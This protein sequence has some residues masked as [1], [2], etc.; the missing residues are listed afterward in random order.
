MKSASSRPKG[1]HYVKYRL[2]NSDV[3]KVA[4]ILSSRSQPRRNGKYGNYINLKNE[5]EPDSVNWDNVSEWKEV[6]YPANVLLLTNE[7]EYAQEVV[8]ARNRELEK[9]TEN[10]VYTTVPYTGQ[11]LISSKWVM[12][13]KYKDGKKVKSGC[14]PICEIGFR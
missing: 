3:W 1:N 10:E 14:I 9:L 4:K 5:E 13:E 7:E 11:K 8:D 12:T 6:P 2:I